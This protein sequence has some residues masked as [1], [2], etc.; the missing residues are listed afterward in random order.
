MVLFLLFAPIMLGKQVKI[1]LLVLQRFIE[2]QVISCLSVE[3]TSFIIKLALKA[4]LISDIKNGSELYNLFFL[5]NF[6]FSVEMD[7]CDLR[8]FQAS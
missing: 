3:E 1:L 4:L 7:I 2:V 5:K 8:H 6:L